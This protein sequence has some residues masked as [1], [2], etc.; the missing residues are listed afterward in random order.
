MSV[1]S[2]LSL[3]G[4]SYPAD[5]L[6]ELLRRTSANNLE[7]VKTLNL[8]SEEL[9]AR[10]SEK[11][12][13]YAQ[14]ALLLAERINYRQ[15]IS[16]ALFYIA[17][18]YQAQ[19][20][21]AKAL[22]YYLRSVKF[23]RSTNQFKGEANALSAVGTIYNNLGDYQQALSYHLQSLKIFEKIQD[24]PGQ[25][26][27][28][29]EIGLIYTA[30]KD[31][32]PARQTFQKV[33]ALVQ[34]KNAPAL[35]G[36]LY[37]SLGKY[38]RARGLFKQALSHY[39][40]SLNAYQLAR[41]PQPEARSLNGL[42]DTYLGL[43]QDNLAL[44]AYLKAL[45][46]QQDLSDNL[47]QAFS[48]QG[49]G[50]LYFQTGNYE[51]AKDYFGRSLRLAQ[52]LDFKEL[53]RDSY[54]HLALIAEKQAQS[55]TA[56]ALYKK[57]KLYNDSLYNQS[58]LALL[59]EMQI[60]YGLDRQEQEAQSQ[61]RR[62]E[63]L[64]QIGV[65][66]SLEII[67]QKRDIRQRNL[68]LGA[69]VVIVVLVSAFLVALNQNRR[70]IRQINIRLSQQN[71]EINRQKTELE[72]KSSELVR[73]YLKITESIRYAESLQKSFLPDSQF[74]QQVLGEHFVI[75]KPREIVSGD[76]Y[77]LSQIGAYTFVAVVDCTGHGV[78]GGFTSIIGQTLL[79]EIVN[80]NQV[81]DPAEI[82]KQLNA[83]VSLAI[84]PANQAFPIGMEAILL[85]L[86][87]NAQSPDEVHLVFAG[88]KRPLY[89]LHPLEATEPPH[90][91]MEEIAG[92]R[93]SIGFLK[94]KEREYASH[95]RI[96]K[97]GDILYLS[98]DG[99]ADQGN[100]QNKRF[101]TSRL[102]EL[103]L[104][105]AHKPAAEQKEILQTALRQHQQKTAQR[106]DITLMGFKI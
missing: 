48:Y 4:Q 105:N 24:T 43:G 78:S 93:Y 66:Q 70:R 74:M 14:Q 49:I 96:L 60:R 103:L 39:Q 13:I 46:I 58:K 9:L 104:E 56:L 59:A 57:Y 20:N 6:N 18:S 73:S 98:T 82:L 27:A 32:E 5:S 75:L 85:R 40:K 15:G 94:Q 2:G 28:L 91:Q 44:E 81:I 31:Y 26:S 83:K 53:M 62:I 95:T 8:M 52:S 55:E 47:G 69:L 7:K 87:K 19:D 42:G 23:Y 88:A 106:D 79:N 38:A 35:Q 21:Y 89:V 84:D 33:E 101:G 90:W 97:K 10:S 11:S 25:V 12:L 3:R 72:T 71:E 22:Q 29:C 17:Q 63:A 99:F 51:R 77:W 16:E 1:L 61:K 80:Q 36:L 67:N 65:Q 41:L 86:E 100:L 45:R 30:L 50:N 102:K 76:F 92:D 34:D 68:I 37:Q 54:Q 64:N